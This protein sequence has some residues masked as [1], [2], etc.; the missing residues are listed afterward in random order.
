M[1]ISCRPVEDESENEVNMEPEKTES[2]C[3]TQTAGLAGEPDME[4]S[5]IP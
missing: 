5:P 4:E 2:L 3:D 1:R